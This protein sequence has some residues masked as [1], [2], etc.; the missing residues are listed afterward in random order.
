MGASVSVNKIGLTVKQQL[1]VNFYEGNG[2]E[3]ARLAGYKGDDNTLGQ[4]AYEN[5]RKP[6]I[7]KALSLRGLKNYPPS[8]RSFLT[9]VISGTVSESEIRFAE[10]LLGNIRDYEASL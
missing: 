9:A 3:A 7:I 2:T 10:D 6:L 1:F 5:L 8:M 4:V